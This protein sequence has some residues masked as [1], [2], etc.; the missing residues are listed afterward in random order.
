[1]WGTNA[2]WK[3]ASL[4]DEQ[5]SRSDT[6]QGRSS[7]QLRH[8]TGSIV[9]QAD[10]VT[11]EKPATPDEWSAIW[12][13]V[14][15]TPLDPDV[16][17][18]WADNGLRVGWV[19]DAE[20]LSRRL[21]S[22]SPDANVVDQFMQQ[23]EVSGDASGL[24]ESIPMRIGKRYEL[25]VCP[26]LSGEQTI[27]ASLD[28]GLIGQTLVSPQPLFAM[29]ANLGELDQTIQLSLKPE[30]QH[31]AMRQSFTPSRAGVRL[32]HRRESWVLGDLELSAELSEGDTILITPS[33]EPMGLGET[34]LTQQSLQR[35]PTCTALKLTVQNI[36][37]IDES[38]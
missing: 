37:R 30:I 8:Q 11:F 3:A 13:W 19:K 24:D 35:Q 15:E 22:L 33:T 20:R 18:R 31:G 28:R 1:M 21:D 23:V 25:T 38:M 16:R 6:A 29:I 2:S 27:L 5:E 36:P 26:A 34:M 4:G 12:Q 32:D 7:R 17:R 10:F 9:L 14:D